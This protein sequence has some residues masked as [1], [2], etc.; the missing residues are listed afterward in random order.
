[1]LAAGSGVYFWRESGTPEQGQQA[2]P[3][4]R[5]GAGGRRAEG[6]PSVLT[7]PARYADVPVT[8]VAVGTAQALQTVMVR[9]QVGGRLLELSFREGQE[10]KKGDVLARIDP[11]IYQAQYEQAL[12][13]RA[14]SEAQLANARLDLGRSNT[15]VASNYVSKQQADTQRAAVAQLEAQVKS[16]QAAIDNSKAYLDYTTILAPIDGRTG[17]RL[18]DQGNVVSGSDIGLVMIAQIRPITV[19]FNLAQ[20]NLRAVNAAAAAGPVAVEALDG[21]NRT[22]LDRGRLEV[23]DNQ[24]DQTTG[25]VKLKAVFPNDD[26]QLWPGQF[27]NVRLTLDTIRN[28]VVVPSGAVQRGPNGPFVYGVADD[29]AVLKNVEVGRQDETSS[30]ITSGLMP[31]E[32]VITTGFARLTNGDPVRIVDAEQPT[33]EASGVTSA[34]PAGQPR[35]EERRRRT[36]AV[37]PGGERSEGERPRRRRQEGQSPGDGAPPV[38]NPAG[39]ARAAGSAGAAGSARAE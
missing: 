21:D 13:K 36:E 32:R 8:L 20:Q 29:K 24:V 27:V 26:Q 28:A 33:A 10:V 15:L 38:S 19:L 2:S 25:T 39:A 16:D 9:P 18:V 23:V 31:P 4:G 37:G 12:A 14:Q 34:P 17:I 35:F 7:A 3:N 6:P 1:V 30:V 5:R 11:T 22:V